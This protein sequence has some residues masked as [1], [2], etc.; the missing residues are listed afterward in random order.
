M[1]FTKKGE[2]GCQLDIST[3]QKIKYREKY[4]I[5]NLEQT[6]RPTNSMSILIS[7]SSESNESEEVTIILS[8]NSSSDSDDTI[9]V[10]YSN[11][12]S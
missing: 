6:L 12:K 5:I 11:S 4:Q 2:K 8:S 1:P 10:L 7:K 3:S 9:Q